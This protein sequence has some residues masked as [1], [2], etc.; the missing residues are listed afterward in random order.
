MAVRKAK[1]GETIYDVISEE[2]YNSNR[3]FYRSG[4]VAINPGDGYLYPLRNNPNDMRPGFIDEGH[5]QFYNHP[6]GQECPIY[7][8]RNIIDFSKAS[9]I[10]DVIESQSKLANAER[11]ILTT[12]DS[13]FVPPTSPDDTPEMSLMKQAITQKHIDIDKYEARFGSN[14][15]NDKRLIKKNS[16]TFGKLRNICNALDI[17]ATLTLE[18]KAGDVPNPMGNRIDICLTD[19]F[20]QEDEDGDK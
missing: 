13:L 18:D 14:F 3:D 17:R 7:S 19:G 6:R 4:P 15:N 10:K 8:S 11:E 2:E 16:I 1:I 20:D 9:C 12:I 5:M